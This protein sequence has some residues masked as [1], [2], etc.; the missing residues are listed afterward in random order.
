ML[1]SALIINA[2]SKFTFLAPER[3]LLFIVCVHC[4]VY[5]LQLKMKWKVM[6]ATSVYALKELSLKGFFSVYL[7]IAL[8]HKICSLGTCRLS[9]IDSVHTLVLKSMVKCDSRF[10]SICFSIGAVVI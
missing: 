10:Q 8:A 9:V 2:A 5:V 4:C 3:M 1:I 6:D 7:F